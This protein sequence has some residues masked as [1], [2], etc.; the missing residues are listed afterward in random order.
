[1]QSIHR[2]LETPPCSQHMPRLILGWAERPGA[3]ARPGTHQGW[4]WP[5]G[6]W[7]RATSC[8]KLQSTMGIVMYTCNVHNLAKSSNKFSRAFSDDVGIPGCSI[9]SDGKD[10]KH[11]DARTKTVSAR[12]VGVQAQTINQHMSTWQNYYKNWKRSTTSSDKPRCKSDR[13]IGRS[14]PKTPGDWV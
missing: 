3:I 11:A 6:G 13:N 5:W 10:C 4:Q 7:S 1:M 14:H 8:A 9:I 2:L 12:Q